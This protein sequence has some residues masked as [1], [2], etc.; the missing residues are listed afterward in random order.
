MRI[1]HIITRLII[2]GAQE[3]TLL[4]V[5]GLRDR[6]GDDVTLITGP[7][8]G[9]EGD[10]F[11]RARKLG[12]SLEIMPE[13]VRAIRP[14]TDLKA[15]R[16]LRKAIR[17]L[18]PDVVHTHSSKAGIVGRAA[19]WDERVPAVVHTIHGLP[20]GPFETPVRNRLYIGVEQWAAQRCHAIVSV[21]DA[22]TAQAL[23]AGVGRAEQYQTVYS[24]MEVD[25][26]L[27]PD[28]P[29]DEV[30]RELGLAAD[31]VAFGTVA[32]LFE[33]KGHDDILAA[34]PAVLAAHPKVRF[35]FIGDGIL[36]DRLMADAE[37]LGVRSAILFTGLVPP[38]RIPD[39]LN[40]LD[41]VVHPSL[42]EGLARVLPQALLVGRPV[43]SYDVDGA[44]EVV[45]PETG[46][47]LPPRSI[48]GLRD[49]ILRLAA[50]PRLRAE[51]GA[52]GRRRFADQFRH[53]TMTDQLRSLYDRLLGEARDS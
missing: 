19:A 17:R 26:F 46:I 24:G 2:G 52:E 5:E 21:C 4:T 10:L 48:E 44:R 22:M 47:L 28:R 40:A 23:A 15:Y 9:P 14:A 43:I 31:E 8:E 34:A 11:D 37:T 50:N 29:R 7:A 38:S 20:F 41:A 45:L 39:L 18:K 32:R 12:P 3:N 13:L 36:R 16:L 33:R 25:A 27:K 49:A 1:I 53:E 35:L 30:R 42:R 6:H 51:M